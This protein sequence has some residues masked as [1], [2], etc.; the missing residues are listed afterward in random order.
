MPFQITSLT[1]ALLLSGATLSASAAEISGKVVHVA[2]GDTITVLAEGRENKIRFN[3]IDC[4]ESSQAYGPEAREATAQAV[5]GNKVTIRSFRLDKY[6]RTIG[7][8][9]LPD[10]S[11]LNRTLVEIGACWWFR[12]YSSDESLGRLEG[13]AKAAKRGLWA[14]DHPIPP[15][16]Y[17]HLK[18]IGEEATETIQ[19]RPMPSISQSAAP[20]KQI[21]GNRRS[22]IYH[23][24][25]CPDYD[26]ISPR[27]RV[28]FGSA[29]DAEQAGYRVAGNC[30]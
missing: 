9:I 11:I 29:T 24:P 23:R 8:V 25:D 3:G 12:K 26:R 27:N 18:N 28:P 7:D 22:K 5:L 15:W 4:P 17:R 16:E 19:P 1:I 21:R 2:D 10:G 30:P 20:S 14:N 6:G 13:E